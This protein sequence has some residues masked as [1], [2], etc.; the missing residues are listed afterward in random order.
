MRRPRILLFA[1]AAT[2]GVAG[3]HPTNVPVT[4]EI[5]IGRVVGRYWHDWEHGRS[6][7]LRV[8]RPGPV[9]SVL[10]IVSTEDWRTCRPWPEF[11]SMWDRDHCE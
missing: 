10:V 4:N 8:V 5:V 1:V 3:C 9:P 2:L 11:P 6:Y 7:Y